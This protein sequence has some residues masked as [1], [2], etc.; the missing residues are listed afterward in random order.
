MTPGSGRPSLARL[1]KG[2]L[3][4]ALIGVTL[5]DGNGPD[6]VQEISYG[7]ADP[8]LVLS[9]GL[10][11]CVAARAVEVLPP[12]LPALRRGFDDGDRGGDKEADG[13]PTLRAQT[14]DLCGKPLTGRRSRRS[15]HPSAH[16]CRGSRR[17]A[18]GR[19]GRAEVRGSRK[20]QPILDPL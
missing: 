3:D 14:T 18:R 20:G 5:P 19:I 2:G 6:L 13:R 4:A 11:H 9:A 1:R 8:S 17:S 7:P 16:S 12:A 10:D 15:R